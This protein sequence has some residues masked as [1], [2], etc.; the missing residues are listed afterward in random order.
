MDGNVGM[1]IAIIAYRVTEV[2]RVGG[3]KSKR[4]VRFL[5]LLDNIKGASKYPKARL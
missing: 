3:Y 1:G 4:V 2:G 5:G